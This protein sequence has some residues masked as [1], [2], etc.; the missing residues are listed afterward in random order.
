MQLNYKHIEDSVKACIKECAH[1][2]H[3]L[4]I[5]LAT[6]LTVSPAYYKILTD[7]SQTEG[8]TDSFACLCKMSR[9]LCNFLSDRIFI[10]KTV[11]VFP[12]SK[13]Y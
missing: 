3:L 6:P 7:S 4:A 8:A 9:Q 12:H 11:T 10:M 13:L 1:G 5:L 2:N